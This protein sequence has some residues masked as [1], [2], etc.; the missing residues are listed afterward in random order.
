MIF[1]LRQ[2]KKA[3]HRIES[4]LEQLLQRRGQVVEADLQGNEA[5]NQGDRE[6]NGDDVELWRD[7]AKNSQGSV[8][9]QQG[10]DDRQG[11]KN[12]GD[13][14]DAASVGD[15]QPGRCGKFAD[16]NRNHGKTLHQ[17]RQ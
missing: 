17:R 5:E 6:A 12:P 15:I 13:K 16:A 7:A 10:N 2:H 11:Q 8:G 14:N 9:D 3:D 1:R 4:V